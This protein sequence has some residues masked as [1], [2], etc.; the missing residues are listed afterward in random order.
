[1]TVLFFLAVSFIVAVNFLAT[2]ERLLLLANVLTVF[3]ALL[4]AFSLIQFFTWDGR[5]YWLRSTGQTVFGPF[6]NRNHFA[7]YMAMLMPVPL[8]L[9][10]RAVRGQA[11]LVYGFAAALMGTSAIVSGSRSGVISMVAALALMAFLRKR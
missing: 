9:I 7:G 3:G 2:R 10:L 1:M 4:G 11:Q 8:G 5:F 6:V